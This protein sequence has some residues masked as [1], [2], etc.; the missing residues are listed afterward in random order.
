MK[1]ATPY[2][3]S[4][5]FGEPERQRVMRHLIL[6][7]CKIY[8]KAHTNPRLYSQ[9]LY[10]VLFNIPQNEIMYDSLIRSQSQRHREDALNQERDFSKLPLHKQHSLML[11]QIGNRNKSYEWFTILQTL[12]HED[13]K[14]QL[15]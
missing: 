10:V 11:G 8:D 15:L 4:A 13:A 14:N 3:G 7:L 5:S 9:L 12:I 6:E 1:I 2:K